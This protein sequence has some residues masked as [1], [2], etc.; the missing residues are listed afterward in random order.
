MAANGISTLSIP[1]GLTATSFTGSYPVATGTFNYDSYGAGF[2]IRKDGGPIDAYINYVL[3]MPAPSARVYTGLAFTYGAAKI[4]FTLNANGI[5]SNVTC[6]DGA[7]GYPY[8]G[9][10]D[11]VITMPGNQFVGG[12]T[13]ANDIQWEYTV[14]VPGGAIT[15]FTYRSGTPPIG[16]IWTFVPANGE[17]SFTRA[18]QTPTTNVELPAETVATWN[19]ATAGAVNLGGNGT[20]ELN[21]T[22]TPVGTEFNIYATELG[23]VGQA[24]KEARQKAKLNL[25]Q[26]KRRGYTLNVDGTIASTVSA[27]LTTT[28]AQSYSD[29]ASMATFRVLN[30][31]GNWDEFFANWDNDTWSCDQFSGSVVTNMTN[32]GDDSPIITIT[33]GT[34][35]TGTFYSFTGDVLA[36]GTPDTTKPFYRVRNEYDI[37]LL[38]TQYVGNTAVKNTAPL[39][40]QQG[41]PWIELPLPVYVMI[42]E[43]ENVQTLETGF[44]NFV[45]E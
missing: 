9:A 27:H 40:L 1:A 15:G 16:R 18:M 4:S 26:A 14:D 29:G 30:R 3:A 32:P 38:P 31:G 12:T 42:M 21:P 28:S 13:P 33:G 7:G 25:A 11:P 5:F 45:T 36:A 44:D 43:D 35:V 2:S 37:N 22:T 39:P 20:N 17:P 34:F 8:G 19:I 10:V 41:R 24:D 6:P 23:A